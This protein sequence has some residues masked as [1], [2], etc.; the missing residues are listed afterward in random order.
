MTGEGEEPAL[1]PAVVPAAHRT[2]TEGPE[3]GGGTNGF[4]TADGFS[5]TDGFGTTDGC[6]LSHAPAPEDPGAGSDW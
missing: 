5:A 1:Q 2:F 3:V 4:G 6:C